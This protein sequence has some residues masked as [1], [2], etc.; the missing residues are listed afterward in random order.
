MS[1]TIEKAYGGLIG[2]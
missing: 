2:D 1:K